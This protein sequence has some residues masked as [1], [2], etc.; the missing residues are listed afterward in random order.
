M[1]RRVYTLHATASLIGHQRQTHTVT[2]TH[3]KAAAPTFMSLFI[4]PPEQKGREGR[5]PSEWR[6]RGARRESERDAQTFTGTAESAVSEWI[7]G[8]GEERCP[9][10]LSLK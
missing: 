1:R 5:K 4:R 10:A 2:L 9:P 7:W 6:A 3:T 8:G